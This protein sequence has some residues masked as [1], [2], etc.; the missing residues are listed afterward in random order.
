MSP[1]FGL[2]RDTNSVVPGTPTNRTPFGLHLMLVYEEKEAR[3]KEEGIGYN[4]HS[5]C[6][7]PTELITRASA[8][9]YFFKGRNYDFDLKNKHIC[10]FTNLMF[11]ESSGSS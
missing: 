2:Y 8:S 10:G 4:S 9:L 6:C 5:H 3:K 11:E 7:G 1:I